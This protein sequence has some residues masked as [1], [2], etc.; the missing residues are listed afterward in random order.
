VFARE[1]VLDFHTPHAH[2]QDISAQVTITTT[3]FLHC[4]LQ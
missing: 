1:T 2:K 3:L 4:D